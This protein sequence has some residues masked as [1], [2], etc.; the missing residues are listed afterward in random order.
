MVV[1]LRVLLWQWEVM[2]GNWRNAR[3][4]VPDLTQAETREALEGLDALSDQLS[5]VERARIREA[6]GG[7]V[8]GRAGSW[9]G[10]GRE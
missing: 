3:A 5:P 10:G 1:Q 8:R 2:V 4:E 6:A 7:A 9:L